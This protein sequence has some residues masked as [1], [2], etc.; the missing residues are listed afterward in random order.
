MLREDWTL[1]QVVVTAFDVHSFNLPTS[2][3][4]FDILLLHYQA[5]CVII[6]QLAKWKFRTLTALVNS[7]AG[8]F[9]Q[10]VF[11]LYCIQVEGEKPGFSHMLLEVDIVRR[12]ASTFFCLL[13]RV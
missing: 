6:D 1:V 12:E 11:P 13:L 2:I 5:Q 10:V 7:C 4:L 9:V 3:C 8:Q